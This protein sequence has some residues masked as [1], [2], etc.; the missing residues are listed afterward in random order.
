MSGGQGLLPVL[1]DVLK[2]MQ[3]KLL[4]AVAFIVLALLE[5]SMWYLW[6]VS[7]AGNANHFFAVTLLFGVWQVTFMNLQSDS[8]QLHCI[9]S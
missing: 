9:T 6:K 3:G 1:V 7:G 2:D 5:P 4:L 8:T